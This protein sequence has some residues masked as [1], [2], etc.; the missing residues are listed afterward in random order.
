[1]WILD[2]ETA[3]KVTWSRFSYLKWDLA[4]LQFAIVQHTFSVLWNTEILKKI[5]TENWLNV[6]CK[7]FLPIIPPVFIKQ[8]VMQRMARLEPKD[9][10]YCFD[11]DWQCLV[12]SAEHTLWPI[13]MDELLNES[14]FPIR[15]IWYST[16]FRREA[17]SYWKDVK[18]IL[19]QHQFDKLEMESFCLP[20]NSVEEQNFFVAVQS[21]LVSSLWLPHQIVHICTWDMWWPDT[22]Q[23]DIET[24]M[25]WQNRY[26]ET[27]T[28]DLMWDYQ[29]RRLNIKVKRDNWDKQ[30]VHMNDWTAFAIWR[31]LI[32][33]MENN[34]Q[35]DWTIIVPEVL[36]KYVWKDVI[37]N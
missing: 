10:R 29:S 31:I 5:I 9:E 28:S 11:E 2:T 21:Y 36:R 30:L 14:N 34:Q 27:H 24:W 32:A 33:I 25:P 12:W 16:A 23:F 37:T 20:E 15:Y 7:P 3:W 1:L 26:R 6:V 8:E 22:R 18:W 13:H 4:L 17:G 19:R 35:E